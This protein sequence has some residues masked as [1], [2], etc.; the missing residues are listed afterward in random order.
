[1]S[2]GKRIREARESKK[3]TQ[4]EL[5]AKLGVTPAAI[6]NYEMD[7]TYPKGAIM[8]KLFDALDVDANFLFRDELPKGTAQI[9][10]AER[11]FLAKYRNLDDYGRKTVD[12]VISAE[13]ERVT[14]EREKNR[15]V[16]TGKITRVIYYDVPVSAGHGELLDESGYVTLDVMEP[17]PEGTEYIV[18]VCG[19]SMEPTYSD[20]DKLYIQPQNDVAPGEIGLFLVNDQVY[21]KERTDAGLKSHNTKYA[22]IRFR[23][24]DTLKCLGK[25]LGV[26]EKYK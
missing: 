7:T 20:G 2:I 26:C 3:M 21:V 18:R 23:D 6:T 8:Y 22:P 17:V 11:S 1:M 10:F 25:V 14:A 15:F 19:D 4:T 12:S 13:T 24:S 9:S 5:A 16:Q